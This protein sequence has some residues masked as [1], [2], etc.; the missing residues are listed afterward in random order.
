MKS[1]L[2]YFIFPL[3]SW[4]CY[5]QIPRPIIHE[6]HRFDVRTVLLVDGKSKIEQPQ[7][8]SDNKHLIFKR[9]NSWRKVD[10]MQ[11]SLIPAEWNHQS[12]G[13]NTYD[14]LDSITTSERIPTTS[15]QS[16]ITSKGIVYQFITTAKGTTQ[17]QKVNGRKKS[18][19]WETGGDICHSIVLSPNEAF[20]AYV[21]DL[22]GLMIYCINKKTIRTNLSVSARNINKA[23]H[24][25]TKKDARKVEHLLNH[26]AKKDSSSAEAIVW[27]AYLKN[28]VGSREDAIRLMN[29]AVTKNPQ[30]AYYFLFRGQLLSAVGNAEGAKDSFLYYN[31]IK[32]YDH[33]GFYELGILSEK[34]GNKQEACAYFSEAS[35]YGSSLATEK[36]KL[37]CN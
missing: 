17:L 36:L 2:A 11:V 12:I 3:F 22:N 4:M 15:A 7:W 19:I 8:T 9:G 27:K 23:L 28:Y 30:N 29:R 32:P 33:H 10:L 16:V 31:T 37:S 25:F 24:L 13:I 20:L 14:V 5:G 18:V 21:S 34:V 6:M 35:R 1:V 26:A